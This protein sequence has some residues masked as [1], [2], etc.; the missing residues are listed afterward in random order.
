MEKS[1]NTDPIF[2]QRIN[3]M[4]AYD[5]FRTRVTNRS[6][7]EKGTGEVRAGAIFSRFWAGIGA[8][9]LESPRCAAISGGWVSREIG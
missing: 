6:I 1:E 9:L 5:A 4:I 8:R 3:G 7:T 2:Y